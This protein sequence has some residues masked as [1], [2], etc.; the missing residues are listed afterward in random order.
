M[1]VH[2][3]SG[4]LSNYRTLPQ[5]RARLAVL[6]AKAD[7]IVAY[8]ATLDPSVLD[9]KQLVTMVEQKRTLGVDTYPPRAFTS[10]RRGIDILK[11]REKRLVWEEFEFFRQSWTIGIDLDGARI[12]DLHVPRPSL[13]ERLTRRAA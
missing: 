6:Y 5:V 13:C 11:A 3:A 8:N 7:R 12:A 2:N 4:P 1:S 10:L 9:E